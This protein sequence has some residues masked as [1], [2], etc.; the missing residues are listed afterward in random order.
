MTS[1]MNMDAIID[2]ITCPITQDVMKDPVQGNDGQTYERN[3]IV[4]WLNEKRI[5]PQTR[6]PMSVND[7]KVNASIRFLCDKYH[8][9]EFGTVSNT[10]KQAS[11]STSN[12]KLD[13]KVFKNNENQIMLNFS[14]DEES[15]PKDLEFGHLSQDVVLVIDRSG[16]M[17][18]AVEAKDS[19]GSNIEAGFSIQDIVNHS[20]K[21]VAK[22]L[23]KNSRLSVVIF[24]NIVEVLFDLMFMTE[25]NKSTALAK[26]ATIKPRGQTNIWGAIE[27]A[28]QILDGR[29]DKS[30]NG[31]I[32]MLTDGQP[33]I[34]PARGEIETLKRVRKTKNFTTPIYT[35]GFGYNLK[36]ELLYDMAKYANGGNGHIPD[37][38]LIATVFCNFIGTIL[39][40]VALNVQLHIVEKKAFNKD[41][42]MGDYAMQKDNG[43][44]I[45]D[46]GTIQIGQTRNIVL[47]TELD[48]YFSYYYTYKIGG[49]SYKSE[50]YYVNNSYITS[51]SFNNDVN[52]NIKRYILVDG[53]RKMLN[54]N[55]CN[56]NFE[57][58]TIFNQLDK[59]LKEG[60]ISDVLTQ[61]MIK[62]LIGD[63]SN[64]GQIK[65]AVSNMVYFKR[66]GEF[67]LDQLSRSLNQQIKPNF[68]DESCLFGGSIFEEI[69]DKASDIFDTMTPPTPSL[70]LKNTSSYSG[71][72]TT[73]SP[74]PMV[75]MS[76]FNDIGGGCFHNNCKITM[77]NGEKIP[78]KNL[79]KGDSILSINE[80]NNFVNANV[81]TIVETQITTKLREMVH[82][83]NGLIITPWHPIKLNNEWVFPNNIVSPTTTTCDS[84]ITLVLDN[85]HIGFINET[86]CIML[87]H[88]FKE[89]ILD[90]PYYG[91]SKVIEDLKKNY[92]YAMGHVVLKDNE[93]SFIKENNVTKK[94]I[95]TSNVR[96][97]ATLVKSF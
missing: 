30:R 78:I 79:K 32:L 37:G 46:I 22:T 33:N 23:D 20:A 29:Q 66:W 11:V 52:I 65:L 64:D 51:L 45:Y 80:N 24:D 61:G 26:I 97:S 67:Y 36:P 7:L 55:R 75:S 15:F 9:G 41:I 25:I 63:G 34:S 53:I 84:M 91:T 17:Q 35:F 48:D 12:I 95:I 82:L 72:Y 73:P 28:I 16:S 92:G 62:N 60:T 87:G 76:A 2:S 3:A 85:Y 42:L 13:H 88:N 83:E 86:P 89:S 21:T 38:N 40:T 56:L 31:A 74:R 43:E 57:A 81:V 39:T 54:Y 77:A 96:S 94:M 10:R 19:T 5:S 50:E 1:N 49:Q 6:E 69:V 14:I 27:Q 47:D 44:L 71:Y 4:K 8:A 58:L 59:T 90:H 68:K 18:A 93:L 70:S